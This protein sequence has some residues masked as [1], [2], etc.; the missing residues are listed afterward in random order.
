MLDLVNELRLIHGIISMLNWVSCVNHTDLRK[1]T[2]TVPQLSQVFICH[3]LDTLWHKEILSMHILERALE[4]TGLKG[5]AQKA[6]QWQLGEAG[7]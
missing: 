5:L 3:I 1:H 4:Q 6:Q 7:I 2:Q